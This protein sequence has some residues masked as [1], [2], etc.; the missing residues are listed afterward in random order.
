MQRFYT[1]LLLFVPCLF[2][3]NNLLAQKAQKV[4]LT[5]T[6][7]RAPLQLPKGKA[8]IDVS[9]LLPG[10]TY[11]VVAI[12][13]V[14]GQKAIFEISPDDNAG[15]SQLSAEPSV[16]NTL[17]FMA[18]KETERLVV[19]SNSLENGKEVPM[20]LSVSCLSCE[21]EAEAPW[22]KAFWEKVQ[23]VSGGSSSPDNVTVLQTTGGATA[24]SLINNTLIGGSCFDVTNPTSFGPTASR[25]TFSNGQSNIQINTGVVLCNGNVNILPGPNN[26][27][28]VSGNTAGFGVNTADDADLA[29]LSTGNQWDLIKLEFDFKPTADVL[30][31]DFVFGSEE[32]CEWANSNFNDVFGFFISGPGIT[33]N[34]N[35]ALLPGGSTPVTINNV[36][37]VNNTGFYVNNNTNN[38]CQSI[39]AFALPECQLDGWTSVLTAEATVQPC[40][41]YHIK[42][43]LA[44][45]TDGN[46]AS[47]VFLRA[48]SFDAGGGAKA[49]TVY[50]AGQTFVYEGCGQGYIKFLRGSG[51]I[52]VP[53]DIHFTIGGNSTATPGLDYGT[54]TSPVTIPAG[55]TEILIP[56]NVFTD[57]DIEG[58]ETILILLDNPCSCTQTP[59]TF[60]IKDKPPLVTDLTDKVVCGNS[61]TLSP[62]TTGG[63][64][65][66]TYLW[67]T[68]A[69]GPTLTVTQQGVNTFTVT[70]TDNCGA[71]ATA[72]AEV[73]LTP[74]PT[75]ALSGSG[76]LCEG[77]PNDINLN[78]TLTGTAPWEVVMN[79]QT[80]TFNSSPGIIT[81]S[82]P[83]TYSLSSV[84]STVS[85]CTGTATGTVNIVEYN[86]NVSLNAVDPPC[87]GVNNGTITATPS[88]GGTPYTYVWNPGGAGGATKNNLGP[89]TYS[90]TVTDS[91]GCTES[92]E[93]TLTEPPP[94]TATTANPVNI[95]C[96]NPI[97]T[98]DVEPD[99]GTPG[100]SFHWSNGNNTQTPSFTAGGTYTVT[101]TDSHN[102]TK[103]A[104]VTISSNLAQ[105]TAVIAPPT[106]LTCVTTEI[107]LNGNGSSSGSDFTYEWG[108]PSF[109]CCETTLSPQINEGGTYTL[110]VT[111][112]TNG[113]TKTASVT[114]T[115]NNTPPN[116]VAS[117][118]NISCST[119]VVTINGSGSSTGAGISY[120]WTTPDGNFVCC[121]NTLN[122]QVNQAG[123]YNLVVS[124]ANTG[125]TAETSVTISGNTI[126]PDATIL[127]PGMVTCFTPEIELDAS[128]SSQ[129]G[130]FSYNWNASN[131]GSITGGGNSLNPTINHSGTYILT[132]TD[133]DNNCTKTASVTV[134]QNTTLPTAVA[135]APG[136]ID[137]THLT[138]TLNGNGSSTGTDFSYLW[139]TNDGSIAS[140]ETTLQPV[141]NA[142]GT[143]TLLV[144]N[145]ANGCTKEVSVTVN[146]NMT[147]PEADAG[148]E[149]ELNCYHPTQQLSGSGSTGSNFIKQ[150]TANPGNISS[151]GN[152][153]NPTVNQPGTYTLLVTNN[154]NGCTASSEVTVTS[155]F[156]T[157]VAQIAPPGIVNCYTPEIELDASGSTG[158]N[159]QFNWSTANGNI[160]GG[161]GSAN[162]TVNQAGTYKVTVTDTESGCT[163]TAQV[164]V[165]SNLALPVATASINQIIDC[166]HPSVTINGNGSSTG[167]NFTYLWTSDDG[168]IVSGETTLNPVV[169]Q[170]GTYT[171]LVTNAVNGCTKEVSVTVQQDQSVP[172]ADA[173]EDLELNCFHPTVQLQ[174]SG[175]TGSPYTRSWA[176]SPGNIVNGGGTF[177]PTVNQPGVYILSV[178]N[179]ATGCTSTDEVTVSSNFET[180]VAQIEPPAVLT[181]AVVEIELDASGSVGANLLFN[182]ATTNGHITSGNDTPHPTIDK[183]G[184]YKVTV[185]NSESGCTHTAQVVVTQNIVPPLAE[186]GP[187][188]NL[189]CLAPTLSLNGTGSSTNNVSYY[190]DT[191]NG[192]IVSGETTLTPVI[193]KAG[194]Y[195]L[196]VTNNLNGCTAS[197]LVTVSSSQ[198]LP[199]ADA[200][201]D[202]ELNCANL[203][204]TLSGGSS[205][206]NLQYQWT[207]APGHI[208]SGGNT[209]NPK[210][211]AAGVYTIL[212][213]NP[214]NGCT[215]TDEVSVDNN[216]VYPAPLIVT[217]QQL[218]CTLTT[219]PLDASASTTGPL[220]NFVWTTTNGHFVTGANTAKPEVD[221]P[222]VYLLT[223]TNTDN[224]CTATASVTVT[225]DIAL[226]VAQ[227]AAPAL[228]TCQFPTMTLNGNGSS[229]GPAFTYEW[230]TVDGH[231]VSGDKSLQPLINQVGTYTLTVFN[232][233]NGCTQTVTTT[234]ASNQMFP[235]ASAGL[236]QNLTCQFPQLSL[237]GNG[238]SQGP[239]YTYLWT[240][241]NGH[242]VAGASTL[243]PQVDKSGAYE[244]LVVN[245]Q[246]G[247]TATASVAIGADFSAP[248]AIVA[249]GGVLSCT[250]HSLT[251]DG[252]GSSTA[253][254]IYQWNSVQ[255]N[256]LNGD[257]TLQPEVNA[258]GT[259]VL[260]V[261]N[262]LNGCT[263][264]SSTDVIADASLPVA[265]AGPPDTLTCKVKT[266]TINANASSQGSNFSYLWSG[267]G[268]LN[269]HTT[270]APTIQ[271]P[272]A[273]ELTVTNTTNGCTAISVVNIAQDIAL[274]TAEAGPPN[275]LNCTILTLDLDG[276]PSSTGVLFAYAWTTSTGHFVLGEH[277]PTPTVDKPGIY[278]LL[279]S[280]T[281]NGCTATDAVTITQDI[282]LPQAEAG[283]SKT[284]TCSNPTIAVSGSGSTGSQYQYQWTTLD[285]NIAA[286]ANTLM[287]VVD[288][289]GTY[290]L[291]ITNT[292]NTCTATDFV[293]IHKD[294][295]VP[296]ALAEVVGE[297]NCTVKQLTLSGIK[298]SAGPTITY[299]WTA[300]AG[301]H[302]VNGGNTL[303]PTVD[304]P[305]QYVL[306]VFNTANNCKSSSTVQVNLNIT[307]P[308]A[309]AGAPAIISCTHPVLS[310]DGSG[311]SAGASFS[312]LWS[313]VDGKILSGDTTLA[314]QVNASG[315]YKIMVTDQTNGCTAESSVQIIRDQNTPEAKP[316]ASPTLTCAVSSLQLN[317]TASSLG[318]QFTYLWTTP[319]GQILS[320]ETT[321]T[322]TIGQPG[323]YILLV[324]N[325]QNGCSSEASV[326][327]NQNIVPPLASAGQAPTLTCTVLNAPLDGTASSIG[328]DFRYQWSTSDGVLVGGDKTLQPTVGAPG[329][330]TLLVTNIAT[331][332]TNTASVQALEDVTPP[333]AAA[334]V[335]AELTCKV[336]NLPLNGAGS[337]LGSTYTYL[338]TTQSGKIESGETGLAPTVSQPGLYKIQVTN[339]LNG[340]THT[341]TVTVNQNIQPPTAN[342]GADGLLTCAV[343]QLNLSG[344]GAGG[345]SGVAY[346]WT[347][348]GIVSGGNTSAPTIHTVGA[349]TLS[350]TDLYNGCSSTDQVQVG[351]D[352]IPPTVAI[353]LPGEL[354]CL[355]ISVA[356]NGTGSSSGPAYSYQ[357]SGPGIVQGATTTTPTVN[358]PGIYTLSVA[359]SSN[360]CTHSATASVSQNIQAPV[361]EANNGFELTCSV[362]EGALSAAG[363]Y[364]G[365]GFAYAWSTTDGFIVSGKNTAQPLVNAPGAYLLV[366]TNAQNGCTST[367]QVQVVRN[368]NYPSA[369]KL[370]TDLPACGGQPGSILFE[371]VTGGVGP[372]L[373]SIDGGNKFLTA[374]EF[375]KLS[376]GSYPLLVQDANGCEYA[377]TLTFPV[378]VE[379]EVTL[380]PE[381]HISF[382]AS[383]TLTATL[384]IPLSQ[385]DTII[386]APLEGLT[387]TT[388]PNVVLAHPYK[389]TEYLVRVIN[390]DGCEDRAKVRV[391]VD[392]PHIWAPNVF[393]PNKR[394]G[395]N[396]YFLIFS[397]DN[398]VERI[399]TL[400]VFDRWGNQM[401]RNDDVQPNEERLGWDGSFRGKPMNPAVFVW[402]AEVLLKDGQ[403]ILMKGDVTI[404]E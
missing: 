191:S 101:V 21:K 330:Y 255:G 314:P 16:G 170:G 165:T 361:A 13:M 132:V 348:P 8:K 260:Q 155:N 117:A 234:V 112:S 7:V 380:N 129:G 212:V 214:A 99:G 57:V 399:N 164:A 192:N 310:L 309:S 183:A 120:L 87:G 201:P 364:A 395:L 72:S 91:H 267:P 252:T 114:V 266:L 398:T 237:Q 29:T 290:T 222:G 62:T 176:A 51:D 152:T 25:G 54:L 163:S 311:S 357:W 15:L 198:N 199:N 71:T 268:I 275:E 393:S 390:K 369:L 143:Y 94:L 82:G 295:N 205:T 371:E 218:N 246:N 66:L 103:T 107:T 394:D 299:N 55:Q 161:G 217:P 331:G 208:V 89:G 30:K 130:N 343:A 90:V 182:W 172:N 313:T 39:P 138:V 180:P 100:Y 307:P 79:G 336:Q 403:V 253:N 207:A 370:L 366:V 256:I 171:L 259:Y 20:Y 360:G 286:G 151:G 288:A 301:A 27:G 340:C 244:L 354:N 178:T 261:T 23:Q 197:D 400:Q 272:G 230:I 238:S 158:S 363:S 245:T 248:T 67:N 386:W 135:A 291:L 321:L 211:D 298:S 175:S 75:A 270:L 335:S 126:L 49:Q 104:T 235:T 98:A 396:D 26:N 12:G 80:Y 254:S 34:Q 64:T 48:G 284:I 195:T 365:P 93:A 262:T 146:E 50:P 149:K 281:Y 349:Y 356:L 225:Q 209:R 345:A 105:P 166:T 187:A 302:I 139:T 215:A 41:T 384:N 144:T 329:T 346:S 177:N 127:P 337:S 32:Y 78:V 318:P 374:N 42:L 38:P 341:A 279:V 388:Q 122:P 216:V 70:V 159:L 188:V 283:P 304:Q 204:L 242:I 56:V 359:N 316:G 9:G 300:A 84:M 77:V 213:T 402:Y 289:P 203:V 18:S 128:G 43:A 196:E 236:P 97:G 273:Y 115:Q 35:I 133:T 206:A 185:T 14:I 194:T 320:G 141:V 251:L 358:Q 109:V 387:P 226:P 118:G 312:Y 17:Q 45:I 83:G 269:G 137:C 240:T 397:A 179:T 229:V 250:V 326:L 368:T 69:T 381:V 68:N 294:A 200:G 136:Q 210:V 344:Y 40:Q 375:K 4:E 378:P 265:V 401:F 391:R 292:K 145:N 85:G 282:A 113:C 338:W 81:V 339:T 334:A 257:T 389:T 33:G 239:T 231:I 148:P 293:L 333:N 287:P 5:N 37:H 220:P 31:F 59:T 140:G 53:V 22:K 123:T 2:F 76:F 124:N 11:A 280:N 383:A 263:A 247:C 347:G 173:G 61:T 153:Y 119:P 28:A 65:P 73:T 317:G 142:G 392:E 6:W 44:D 150:W 24:S 322:P 219:I 233:N 376:P 306:E 382:G 167:P 264:T 60:I 342:A 121:A 221:K 131:G 227:V 285:G 308:V 46:L 303:T 372:Y 116:A 184:T 186:A 228:L 355:I 63:Q 243:T 325:T 271:Q 351:S 154:A 74:K 134:T 1:T 181:C 19:R 241:Q 352:L 36:N 315:F 106:Q 102:C 276:S 232:N 88:G 223:L 47:A 324:S 249:P 379:P 328:S 52:N 278:E 157:P 353:A 404:V 297:L 367:D 323:I 190:W 377:Q 125:C 168:N 274:P 58:D 96:N 332:C 95:D 10:N 362:N 350:V 160:T 327:V 385:V 202:A 86:V 305:G 296:A 277:T 110:T 111:N 162:P 147:P 108:G 258:V 189:T 169:N 193:D 156:D 319:N 3:Q 174:G 224:F 373:Y 92:A